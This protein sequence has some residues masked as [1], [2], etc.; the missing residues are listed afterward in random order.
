MT[1]TAAFTADILNR[2]SGVTY[3]HVGD[4][5]YCTITDGDMHLDLCGTPADLARLA[6]RLIEAA[7]NVG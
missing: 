4:W 1:S 3:S 7:R 6:Q 5:V 2:T